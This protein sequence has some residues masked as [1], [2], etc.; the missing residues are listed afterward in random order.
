[1]Q[2]FRAVFLD[3][4]GVI[5]RDDG[6]VGEPNRLVLLPHAAEGIRRIRALGYL[7]V[8]ITNQS[9]VARGLFSEADVSRLHGWMGE[10]LAHE[11]AKID[12]FY[13]CPHHPTEGQG[14]YRRQCYCRKPKPG[15]FHQA[16]RELSI[17]IEQSIAV[18]D[19][20]SDLEAAL[21][22]GVPERVLIGP[23]L[24]SPLSIVTRSVDNLLELAILLDKGRP[25]KIRGGH[26]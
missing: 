18:G 2:S 21:N 20:L 26:Y 19:Q 15:L 16:T 24:N 10:I 6:Y 9:G 5:N 3:R 7:V 4:D 14:H 8:V 23:K 25:S 1:M 12:G 13:V 17:R 11:H 22:A